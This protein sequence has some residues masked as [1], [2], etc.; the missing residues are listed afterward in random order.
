M[1]S[2]R[3]KNFKKLYALL[4][5]HV[6]ALAVKSYLLWCKDPWHPS[7]HFKP[8]QEPKWSVRVGDG[9]RAVGKLS[10]DRMLWYWI[11]SH[12]DYNKLLRR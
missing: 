3:S 5:A 8:L 11:G 10:N 2:S 12:E 7:L 9:H 6:Q 4:P 1:I